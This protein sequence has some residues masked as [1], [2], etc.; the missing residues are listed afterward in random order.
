VSEPFLPYGRQDVTEDDI[1]AV[2]QALREPLITQ[3]PHVESFEAAFAEQTGARHAVAFANGT[4][5]LH[6]AAAAAGLG[7]ADRMPTTPLSFVASS[8]CAIFVGARPSFHDVEWASAN[9]DISSAVAEG[10]F[11][12]AKA[13]VV[14][15]LAG[16]PAN[17]EPLQEL[18]RERGL[19]VIEDACHALGGSRGGRPIGGG[20]YADMSCFSLHPVKSMTTGEGGVVT[21][22]DDGLAEKLRTFRTHGMVRA[23][24]SGGP[25]R[26]PWH[27]DVASLGFNYRITDFQCA[28][29]ESQ[30]QRLPQ[31][32][33]QRN[34]LA[35]RYHEQLDGT[36]GLTMPARAADGDVH[37]YHLFVVRFDEGP[38]RRRFMAE[39]LREAGIGTQLH[40][41]PIYHHSSYASLGFGAEDAARCPNAERYYETA[42]SLPMYPGLSN[43]DVERVGAE[44]QRLLAEPVAVT[45]S[46]SDVPSS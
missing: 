21:T 17:L 44:V 24:D 16:L 46:S 6:G 26:G 14:V 7:P 4:G 31:F 15:S 39:R 30:L 35:D 36:P 10:A 23:A 5:A 19:I 37:G 33:E 42:L 29:G 1:A 11:D 40:Y 38:E 22:D 34:R 12:G 27:Y 8:N 18:R 43:A 41:I 20:G 45:T 13:C 3:G 2:A 25:L 28:L 9:L 32:V